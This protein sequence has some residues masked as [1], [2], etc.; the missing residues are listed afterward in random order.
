MN[1]S[2]GAKRHC[3]E[4]HLRC[5][6]A[7]IIAIGGLKAVTA[8]LASPRPPLAQ[9]LIEPAAVRGRIPLGLEQLRQSSDLAPEVDPDAPP[10]VGSGV[11][12]VLDSLTQMDPRYEWGQDDGVYLVRPK[13]SALEASFLDT[14]V[15]RFFVRDVTVSEFVATIHRIFDT[16]YTPRIR[17]QP[18]V[19]QFGV[20]RH[21]QLQTALAKTISFSLTDSTVRHILNEFIRLRR[22]SFWRVDYRGVPAAYE[23]STISICGFDGWNITMSAHPR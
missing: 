16:G 21:E 12:G 15:D 2:Y 13:L 4:K 18:L 9:R 5:L 11:R 8:Q 20:E 14:R 7:V 22:D 10:A 6:G 23:N 1:K 19:T 3:R 17:Q